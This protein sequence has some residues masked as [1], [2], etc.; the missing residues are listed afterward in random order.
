MENSSVK[1]AVFGRLPDGQTADLFTLTNG[2]ITAK[3]TN[4]GT[5]I[6]ELH[7]PDRTGKTADVVLGFDSLEGYLAGHPYFGCTVGRVAN[8]IA[9][10]RFTLDGK[11]YQLAINNGPNSLHG[12]IKGFDKVIWKAE[13]QS[14]AAVKFTHTSP[15]GDENYPGKLDVEVVMT[16]TERDELVIDYT[17]RTDKATPVN[18]TNHSYFNLAGAGSG[19]IKGHVLTLAASHY[20]PTD[21]TSIPTGEIK[22]VSETPYDFTKPIAIGSRFSQLAGTPAGYDNNYVIDG[23]GRALVLAA[24]VVEPS[25]GRV[26]ET[27]TTTPGVQLYTANYL[28][29]THLGKGGQPYNQYAALC[30]ETQFFPDSVNHPNFPSPILRPGE[31][32]RQTTIYKYATAQ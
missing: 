14:G 23:G 1:K 11:T 32:Y 10:G 15:D 24:R 20:T 19:D 16:L 28:N 4:Y 22:P 3:I 2:R 29:G 8:R 26:M 13:P 9:N 12:G 31:V 18:L 25:S 21:S 27:H 6:T 5:I 7:V 30:L 17:A